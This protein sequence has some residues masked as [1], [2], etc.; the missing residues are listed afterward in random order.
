[1]NK[2]KF[3]TA[4]IQYII[5]FSGGVSSLIILLI[6]IFLFTQGFGLFNK[7]KIE[8]G[9]CVAVSNDNPVKSLNATQLKDIFDGNIV[10]WRMVGGL[11]KDIVTFHS[12]DEFFDNPEVDLQS[13]I[14]VVPKE[15]LSECKGM[16]Q[17]DC[18]NI[19]F[20]DVFGSTS[21]LP[22]ATPAPQFGFLPIICGTLW[23]SFIAILIALPLSLGVAIYLSELA[24]KK[25]RNI[26]K[27]SIELLA[28][29]PSVIYGFFGLVVIVPWV[30]RIFNL[31][32]GQNGLTGAI[33]L[34]I[35]AL[36]TIISVAQDSMQACPKSV[37]EGSLAL[38]ATK[39]QTICRV[40]IPQSISGISAAAIL[41]M[42]RAIGETMAVIMLTGNAALMPTSILQPMRTIPSTIAAE[43]GE[44]PMGSA[45]YQ[46]LFLLGCVLFV[47]TLAINL[48]VDF[49]SSKN[50][51]KN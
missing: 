9:Y 7:S 2:N 24:S 21:W 42:G 18:G 19:S 29:V 40:V 49:I 12:I 4:L 14:V 27:P 37:R 35:M 5:K 38:G 16:K 30:Q 41:G 17:L 39:W 15:Y 3:L 33:V 6:V 20:K 51:L 8:D 25:V 46:A 23:V 45:H 11:E 48:L 43:L 36:P 31:D 34:A 28:G 22:T 44:A 1:M 10:S 13:A 47:I 50:K 26:I 32:V